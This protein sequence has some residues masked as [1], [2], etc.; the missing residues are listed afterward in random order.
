MNKTW[1][2]PIHERDKHYIINQIN[3]LHNKRKT[4][5]QPKQVTWGSTITVVYENQSDNKN[6]TWPQSS[7]YPQYFKTKEDH[8]LQQKLHTYQQ[9][10][11]STTWV[12]Y[13]QAQ[14]THHPPTRAFIDKLQLQLQI[15]LQFQL[16]LLAKLELGTSQPQLVIFCIIFGNIMDG[17]CRGLGTHIM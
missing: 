16:K 8:D 15:Q 3:R 2:P 6:N 7:F 11:P 5:G 1:H 17:K 12:G 14:P 4:P 9:L 10:V 13:C